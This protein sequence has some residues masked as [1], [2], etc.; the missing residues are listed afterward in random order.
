[1]VT[2]AEDFGAWYNDV[3]ERAGLSDKR[4]PVKGMNVWTPYGWAVMRRMDGLL[5][6]AFDAAGHG[7]VYFPLLVPEGEFQKESAHIKGFEEDVYWVTHAGK[8]PLDVRLLL[9]P[10][11]ETAMYPV[12]RLWIRS[13]ADLPL[14]VYQIVNTFRYETKVTRTFMRVRELHFFEAH[15][16][17][18]TFE[19]AEAQIREDLAIHGRL[20]RALCL[21]SLVTKRPEWDKFPGAHYSLAADTLMPSGRSLQIATFHNYRDNFA[22]AYD[23]TYEDVD[24]RRRYVHQTTDGMSER[25]LGAIIAAHGD[26]RGVVLPPTI[27]PHQVVVVPIPEKD[28]QAEISAAAEVLAKELGDAYRVHLDE[29][30]VRPGQ[31]FYDWEAKGV[32][33]RVELGPRDLAKGEVTLVRRDTLVRTTVPRDE[34]GA[35][36]GRLLDAIQEEMYAR[37]EAAMRERIVTIERF[38]DAKATI[39]RMG[40][41]GKEACGH[42]IEDRLALS[43]LGTPFEPEP[44][45]GSCIACGEG[46][47]Q[48]VYAAKAY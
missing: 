20:M 31:K 23:I 7:E 43:L 28:R 40:W 2:K 39:N 21:P 5:R 17:H 6:E 24:G 42:T 30:D 34:A 26:D 19:D 29:R 38:E 27:S 22:K 8:N 14:K 11:S 18:A 45:E 41:C 44:F 1:M 47:S 35:A 12:F 25:L 13:H 46:T 3:V 48:V 32:P 33:V 15:T 9:R 36:V 4:Y 10:T 37:A 16:C